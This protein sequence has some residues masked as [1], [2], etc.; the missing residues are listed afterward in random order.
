MTVQKK[1]GSLYSSVVAEHELVKKANV[2]KGTE[3]INFSYKILIIQKK[4]PKKCL[5]YFVTLF[6]NKF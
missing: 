2:F 1:K 6:I 3:Q 5:Q 4:I